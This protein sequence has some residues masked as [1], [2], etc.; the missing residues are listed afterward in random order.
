MPT[1]YVL[2]TINGDHKDAKPIRI[3]IAIIIELKKLHE[4]K[5]ES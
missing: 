2:P 5:L 4:N 3:L 1:K